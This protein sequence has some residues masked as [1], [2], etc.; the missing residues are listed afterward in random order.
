MHTHP[1]VD[2][3][4]H[5]HTHTHTPW[6]GLRTL[7][8]S[9]LGPYL[10]FPPQLP[11]SPHLPLPTG[12]PL[13]QDRFSKG[14]LWPSGLRFKALF[15]LPVLR[16][17]QDRCPLV[18]HCCSRGS[19]SAGSL[20]VH[21]PSPL[22]SF[23]MSLLFYLEILVLSRAHLSPS[24]LIPRSRSL[25]FSCSSNCYLQSAGSQLSAFAP[26]LLMTSTS[27]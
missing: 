11:Q 2:T 12:A 23:C 9:S 27:V 13:H 19:P 10:S 16:G 17:G 6:P 8:Q 7:P 22:L 20:P 5:T 24:H 4:T 15:S 21:W 3:Y 14:P 18:G 26:A 25:L 1:H